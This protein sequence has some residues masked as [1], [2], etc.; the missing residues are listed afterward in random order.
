M[1][2]ARPVMK[3]VADIASFVPVVNTY[4][5]PAAITLHAADSYASG[6]SAGQIVG[7]TAREAGPQLATA[8]M[9]KG[10]TALAG[11]AALVKR[12]PKISN[13]FGHN[14]MIRLV[15]REVTAEGDTVIRGGRV[16]DGIFRKEAYFKTPGGFRRGRRPDLLVRRANGSLYG[17][18]VGK[19]ATDGLPV[20][21]ELE[22]MHDLAVRAN[23]PMRFVP[24]G[25]K[26]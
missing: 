9:Y 2:R 22:A 1:D 10:G 13:I 11:L 16:F 6:A 24:Y 20:T 15:A 23:L 8:G 14:R 18:N 19:L 7:H 12:G 17:I 26:K 4:A 21:R 5:I 3:E 25:G